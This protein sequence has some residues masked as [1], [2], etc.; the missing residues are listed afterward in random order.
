MLCQVATLRVQG[1]NATNFVVRNFKIGKK[2]CT[3]SVFFAGLW[4]LH[5]LSPEHTSAKNFYGENFLP[6]GFFGIKEE[7]IEKHRIFWQGSHNDNLPL[8][9]N[10]LCFSILEILRSLHFLYLL[11]KKKFKK[12]YFYEILQKLSKTF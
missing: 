5:S 1:N 10:V 12:T 8:R 11:G 3:L 7:K 6:L 9:S 4:Q 2:V